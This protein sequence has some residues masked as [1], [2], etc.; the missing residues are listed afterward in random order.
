MPK[1]L[2]PEQKQNL[3]FKISVHSGKI[4]KEKTDWAY[5]STFELR[6]QESYKRMEKTIY[7]YESLKEI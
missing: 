5:L 7:I 1:I 2:K 4:Q 3:K 6:R